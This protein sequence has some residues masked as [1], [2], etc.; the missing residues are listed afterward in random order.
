MR[1][2]GPALGD[3]SYLKSHGLPMFFVL[4]PVLYPKLKKKIKIMAKISVKIR[5]CEE[6]WFQKCVFLAKFGL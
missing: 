2:L 3:A 4:G 1:K 5:L 6:W